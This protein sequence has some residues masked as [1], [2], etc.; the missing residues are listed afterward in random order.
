MPMLQCPVLRLPNS[1]CTI[2]HGSLRSSLEESIFSTGLRGLPSGDL[3]LPILGLAG[4]FEE[5]TRALALFDRVRQIAPVRGV[6]V[7]LDVLPARRVRQPV[8]VLLGDFGHDGAQGLVLDVQ[9]RIWRRQSGLERVDDGAL[10]ALDDQVCVR[11]QR[12]NGVRVAAQHASNRRRRVE[13]CRHGAAER[14]DACD[15]CR[16][17]AG[18]NDVDLRR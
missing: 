9:R 15:G 12:N 4:R 6:S 2:I 10:P 3:L 1:Y 16:G 18:Y 7:V 5:Q 11:L 13:A 14:L 17:G 8:L